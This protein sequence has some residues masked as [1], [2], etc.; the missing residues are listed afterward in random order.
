MN[1]E[2]VLNY[3][4]ENPQV[5]QEFAKMA[6]KKCRQRKYYSCKAIIELVRWDTKIGSN[7]D[8]KVNNNAASLYIRLFLRNHPGYSEHFKLR[9]SMFDEKEL[10]NAQMEI[11]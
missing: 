8:F 4:R 11:F 7:G 3:H 10:D 9:A 1:K 5:Y 6:L 2:Q